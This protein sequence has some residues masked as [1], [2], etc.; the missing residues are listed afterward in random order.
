MVINVGGC[1]FWSCAEGL[2]PT[3]PL[4]ESTLAG[5]SLTHCKMHVTSNC[6]M[7]AAD[8]GTIW[9]TI[10]AC[11]QTMPSQSFERPA[12]ALCCTWCT[13]S[14]R[15]A[16]PMVALVAAAFVLRGVTHTTAACIHALSPLLQLPET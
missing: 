15:I 8:K 6:S 5:P 14:Q 1:E 7:L 4:M 10:T 2:Q 12:D 9:H 3:V 11:W 16:D 13:L